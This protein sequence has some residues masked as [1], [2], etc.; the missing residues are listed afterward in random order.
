MTPEEY[1][2][3]SKKRLAELARLK[4]EMQAGKISKGE[5]KRKQKDYKAWE[6]EQSILQGDQPSGTDSSSVSIS[7]NGNEVKL[8]NSEPTH[9]P[10]SKSKEEKE[11]NTGK[12]LWEEYS[13]IVYDKE[14][15]LP[16]QLEKIKDLI[17]SGKN[18]TDVIQDLGN[19]YAIKYGDKELFQL[20]GKEEE[21]YHFLWHAESARGTPGRKSYIHKAIQYENE[22][23]I[24]FFLERGKDL[25]YRDSDGKRPLDY[26]VSFIK[27]KD[28]KEKFEQMRKDYQMSAEE[29]TEHLKEASY[30][31]NK[32]GL[33]EIKEYVNNGATVNFFINRNN[34]TFAH[35][36]ATMGDEQL[37]EM[38]EKRGIKWDV[39]SGSGTPADAASFYRNHDAVKFF[40]ENHPD[41]MILKD[42]YTRTPLERYLSGNPQIKDEK[43]KSDI[44][45]L[46]TQKAE[47]IVP[48]EEEKKMTADEATK[49][50]K[51]LMSK[52]QHS[53]DFKGKLD[54]IKSLIKQEA[55]PN[56]ILDEDQTTFVHLA[57]A[58]G[59]RELL[60]MIDE[61]AD[62]KAATK[63]DKEIPIHYVFNSQLKE[64][65]IKFFL[66]KYPEL[67]D[68][69]NKAG[70][71]PLGAYFELYGYKITDKNLYDHLKDMKNKQRETIGKA[72]AKDETI[73]PPEEEKKMTP[74]E[75]L[76][77]L[78]DLYKDQNSARDDETKKVK[79]EDVRNLVSL[80]DNST[81]NQTIYHDTYDVMLGDLAIDFG[82]EELFKLLDEKGFDWKK[83]QEN[84]RISIGA[85]LSGNE[86]SLL[87]L[88]EKGLL[89][90]D[91]TDL[92]EK[93]TAQDI[94]KNRFSN[95]DDLLKRISEVEKSSEADV[96]EEEGKPADEREPAPEPAPETTPEP[97]PAPKKTKEEEW[98]EQ[99]FDLAR[100]D[101]FT[102]ENL[103]KL[104]DAGVNLNCRNK[105]GIPTLHKL[106]HL[107]GVDN[108]KLAEYVETFIKK[109]KVDINEVDTPAPHG[110]N[111]TAVRWAAEKKDNLEVL[112]VLAKLG[113]DFTI[114]D[115]HGS[116]PRSSDPEMKA[117]IE[118]TIGEQKKGRAEVHTDES[119]V[120]GG[121]PPPETPVPPENDG[122][123]EE[124]D[125]DPSG[126]DPDAN[127]DDGEINTEKLNIQEGILGFWKEIEK[128]NPELYES[129]GKPAEMFDH[130]ELAEEKRKAMFE[131]FQRDPELVKKYKDTVSKILETDEG[132]EIFQRIFKDRTGNV[133]MDDIINAL[134]GNGNSSGSGNNGI[135]QPAPASGPDLGKRLGD[136][137]KG[138]TDEFF[139]NVFEANHKTAEDF[140]EAFLFNLLA[141]PLNAANILLTKEY[142]DDEK[143]LLKKILNEMKNKD[144]GGRDGRD[145][146][147]G[148]GG[149]E[150]G[151]DGN[152]PGG[153]GPGGYGQPINIHIHDL[154]NNS[155]H[156]NVNPTI[157]VGGKTEDARESGT[158]INNVSD[159]II[160]RL[161]DSLDKNTNLHADAE[162]VFADMLKTVNERY[163]KLLE[164]INKNG[165]ELEKQRL[166]L[167]KEKEALKAATEQKKLELEKEIKEKE[168]A[169]REKELVHKKE[170]AELEAKR[171]QE[172][173]NVTSQTAQSIIQAAIDSR[174]IAKEEGDKLLDTIAKISADA[175]KGL[176]INAKTLSEGHKANVDALNKQTDALAQTGE[177]I[178]NMVKHGA[179]KVESMI[180]TASGNAKDMTDTTSNNAKD[181]TDNAVNKS[182]GVAENATNKAAETAQKGLSVV[183]ALSNNETEKKKI[184]E[185][186]RTKRELEQLKVEQA[187]IEA[188]AEVAIQKAKTEAEKARITA[189]MKVKL[190]EIQKTEKEIEASRILAKG[191]IYA[192]HENGGIAPSSTTPPPKPPK[193]GK[194]GNGPE[195]DEK[196]PKDGLNLPK[197]SSKKVKDAI[198]GYY[199]ELKKEGTEEQVAKFEEFINGQKAADFKQLADALMLNAKHP[200]ILASLRLTKQGEL[201][202][203][204]LKK[205]DV[206]RAF[207]GAGLDI[208]NTET[209][210]KVKKSKTILD[211][212][213]KLSEDGRNH[214]ENKTPEDVDK[215]VKG[216]RKKTSQSKQKQTKDESKS[217]TLRQKFDGRP[218]GR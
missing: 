98:Q 82:N 158:R 182:A 188:E 175:T 108:K 152:G 115:V 189:D 26:D 113:A 169:L 200:E 19:N 78:K 145:G 1:E 87:Y 136:A 72:E 161:L 74:E 20:L 17:R 100:K 171:E 166:A 163:A 193:E 46:L 203:N 77:K 7:I 128:T 183:E 11:R 31:G 165:T 131:A 195:G 54:E 64:E 125:N 134:T 124:N 209:L 24:R 33:A 126:D 88:A 65:N 117:F 178:E 116:L 92:D 37:L 93:E 159:T 135:D 119:K 16:E 196:S 143:K 86:T 130:P 172:R 101:Q 104:I 144:N 32:H 69:K 50:L 66:E 23:A 35:V 147:D 47:T 176:E 198:N 149:G 170:M 127:E 141:Y 59:D 191:K 36:V 217:P 71:S 162:K 60:E 70:Q 40:V 49:A 156:N 205:K 138:A 186:E 154:V 10:V 137:L 96:V 44:E 53:E 94:I 207:E 194:G 132:K 120:D 201:N 218:S 51:K 68:V 174:T 21:K 27:D 210:E 45:K 129:L 167:E 95:S 90:L 179:D 187:R 43:L 67:F 206:Q 151:P 15:S 212:L 122:N 177:R 38:V 107:D 208:N 73:V 85:A 18:L 76:K 202:K 6:A 61:K 63:Q 110:D 8:E 185:E 118:K 114:P 148:R 42:K 153:Y 139:K 52:V 109:A 62:W 140:A 204:D 75:A 146:E 89:N 190:A 123:E 79:L 160:A 173:L 102:D 22:D 111:W 41:L 2:E 184:E 142:E 12:V 112:K 99:V 25:A 28:L 168:A 5:Y 58:M 197:N 121:T 57:T 9:E 199:D 84:A 4:I 214:P 3:E 13:D 216:M 97:A 14:L 211:R 150:R 103:Q 180:N 105:A 155:G 133:S 106:V 30:F 48:P 39:S 83:Q 213:D 29:A 91:E 80:L 81:I 157:T 34:D 164:E 181:M 56:I 192:P 215:K 55:N